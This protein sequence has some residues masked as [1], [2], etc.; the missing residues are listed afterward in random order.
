MLAVWRRSRCYRKARAAKR[1][2]PRPSVK[3]ALRKGLTLIVIG[4]G[5][6]G[7]T[8]VAAALALAT[9]SQGL[10]T[11]VI[12]VDPARRL[13]DALG[14]QRL[15]ARPSAIDPRRL[16]AAGFDP[17]MH[18]AAMVLDVRRTWDSLV[19]RFVPSRAQRQRILANSFYRGLSE[20]FA[21][22][23]AYAALEQF[24]QLR[25]SRAFDIIVVDTPPAAHTFEF[26]EAPANL[27]HLLES[28]TARWLARSHS[29]RRPLALASSAMRF[30]AAQLERFAGV[31]TLADAG[32][33]FAATLAA[34][35]ELS[36]R[37]RTIAEAMRSR[38]VEFVLVTT[39]EPSR[40][41][42]A[43][44]TAVRMR[45]AGL[46][47]RAIVFNRLTDE[48]ALQSLRENPSAMP[49][50]RSI[51]DLTNAIDL[52]PATIPQAAA[53]AT[54][55]KQRNA[56]AR[57]RIQE[58]AAFAQKLPAR[59]EIIL[60]PE[61]AEAVNDLGG[62]KPMVEILLGPDGR[63]LLSAASRPFKPAAA[64]KSRAKFARTAN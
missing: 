34:A 1:R 60:A 12:T 53:I 55:F 63:Q 51:A 36:D 31:K 48:K 32:E 9:A 5:G 2:T 38:S 54:F 13:R 8:T 26:I 49:R 19:E 50:A 11:G 33:F 39:P 21:G 24:H 4:P 3:Q 44:E 64:P 7:K 15:R 52:D 6:V 40:L 47:L 29:E 37:F 22:A 23:D 56:A 25:E 35:R 20:Q 16:Q 17:G 46:R 41:T 42:E 62:L 59:M 27:Q 43:Y 57:A 10:A 14:I 58:A 45:A 61:F 18:I 30:V 28:R